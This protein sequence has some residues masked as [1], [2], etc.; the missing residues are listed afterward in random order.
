[1]L[2]SQSLQVRQQVGLVVFGQAI[3]KRRHT[4]P[5]LFNLFENVSVGDG[6][7][8]RLQLRF[9]EK[10]LQTRPSLSLR[11]RGMMA[12][13]A[14]LVEKFIALFG[15]CLGLGGPGERQ[16]RQNCEAGETMGEF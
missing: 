5:A 16:Q 2:L 7:A 3:L 15:I 9:G 8:V 1:M 10:Q 12:G 11:T 6:L 14:L 4:V 13:G